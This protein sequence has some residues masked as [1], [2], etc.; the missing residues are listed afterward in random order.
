MKIKQPISSLRQLIIEDIKS[1]PYFIDPKKPNHYDIWILLQ[2]V[3]RIISKTVDKCILEPILIKLINDQIRSCTDSILELV[4]EDIME[5]E[6]SAFISEKIDKYYDLSL[7]LELYE[8][9][10]NLKKLR[11]IYNE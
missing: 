11:K 2:L 7:E 1:I 8:V 6:I 10:E 5:I 4:E 9:C 3:I